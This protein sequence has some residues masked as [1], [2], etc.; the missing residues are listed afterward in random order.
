MVNMNNI[1]IGYSCLS[2][3]LY[4][5]RHGKDKHTALDK[6]DATRDVHAAIVE[7]MLDGMPEGAT[8][9]VTFDGKQWYE[10][11]VKPIPRPEE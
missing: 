5:Y 8:Q 11:T 9:N 2:K 1:G 4:L 6:R 3:K 10:I 7:A